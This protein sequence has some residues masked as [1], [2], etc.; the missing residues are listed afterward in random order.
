MWKAAAPMVIILQIVGQED[1]EP[2]GG[3]TVSRKWSHTAVLVPAF[4]TFHYMGIP[5]PVCPWSADPIRAWGDGKMSFKVRLEEAEAREAESLP[6]LTY[7]I[8]E[9]S[10]SSKVRKHGSTLG[11]W[12]FLYSSFESWWQL[13]PLSWNKCL[14]TPY[15]LCNVSRVLNSEK[16]PSGG[17]GYIL[18]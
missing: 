11:L 6:Y 14:V 15:F 13:Q 5:P 3:R 16:P 7:H 18:L 4:C 1:P 17:L 12:C 9:A 2:G 8:L 10:T